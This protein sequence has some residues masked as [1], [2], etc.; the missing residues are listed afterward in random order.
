MIK[1]KFRCPHCHQRAIGLGQKLTMGPLR[2]GACQNCGREINIS[3]TG[4]LF[5]ALPLVIAIYA[6]GHFTGFADFFIALAAIF[7]SLA[8][9]L[10][11]VP[12]RIKNQET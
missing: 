10:F 4:M 3:F 7:A 5:Y 2:S 6:G 11:L 1:L 9:S 8:I 12:L